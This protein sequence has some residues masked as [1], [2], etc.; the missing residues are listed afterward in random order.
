MTQTAI[1]IRTGLATTGL[2]EASVSISL[3]FEVL[4]LGMVK[5]SF[6]REQLFTYAILGFAFSQATRLFALMMAF[7]LY[8]I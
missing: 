4:I 1:I 2:I 5:N 6:L 7:L 8:V 3:V